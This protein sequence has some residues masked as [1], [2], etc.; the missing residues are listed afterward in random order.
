M[1]LAAKALLDETL[2]RYTVKSPPVN[3]LIGGN[4][5]KKHDLRPK[6]EK[7]KSKIGTPLPGTENEKWVTPVV[8]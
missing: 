5:W 3:L 6:L 4:V 7:R 1:H 2:V 8:L